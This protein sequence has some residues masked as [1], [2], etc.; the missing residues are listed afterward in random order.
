MK[1]SYI[2]KVEIMYD[3]FNHTLFADMLPRCNVKIV[4]LRKAYYAAFDPNTFTLEINARAIKQDGHDV[5]EAVLHEMVHV[6]QYVIHDNE[7]ML[8]DEDYFDRLAEV[9]EQAQVDFDHAFYNVAL[10]MGFNF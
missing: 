2:T 8:H 10:A 5:R 7:D 3:M 6:E 9:C 4:K 1:K